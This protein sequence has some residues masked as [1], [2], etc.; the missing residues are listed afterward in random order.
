[1]AVFEAV[2]GRGTVQA[3]SGR[4]MFEGKAQRYDIAVAG[5]PN[6]GIERPPPSGRIL[7]IAVDDCPDE[8]E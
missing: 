5:M 2:S 7:A 8:P 4:I 6:R 3:A 1:M